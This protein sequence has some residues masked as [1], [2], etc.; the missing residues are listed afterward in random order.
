MRANERERTRARDVGELSE[1]RGEAITRDGKTAGSSRFDGSSSTV[2]WRAPLEPR[3][4]TRMANLKLRFAGYFRVPGGGTTMAPAVRGI[5]G[6]QNA[7][8]RLLPYRPAISVD[9]E[10]DLRIFKIRFSRSRIPGDSLN[11]GMSFRRN[12]L[13]K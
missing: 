5:W 3:D 2:R 8:R 4:I 7:V 11:D 1:N 12:A 6:A 9:G 10:P 13:R